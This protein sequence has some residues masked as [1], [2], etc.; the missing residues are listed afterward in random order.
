MPNVSSL[1]RMFAQRATCLKVIK[2]RSGNVLH[3][4]IIIH[5]DYVIWPHRMDAVDRFVSLCV[6]W[7]QP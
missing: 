3:R 1:V 6:C 5:V 7:T 2:L 4:R